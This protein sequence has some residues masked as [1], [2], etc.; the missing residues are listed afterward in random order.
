MRLLYSTYHSPVHRIES[1]LTGVPRLEG[2]LEQVTQ[3]LVGRQERGLLGG[4]GNLLA[5]G[6][7]ARREPGLSWLQSLKPWRV[8]GWHEGWTGKPLQ[9]PEFALAAAGDI[10]GQATDNIPRMAGFINLLKKGVDPQEAMRQVNLSLVSYNPRD[11]TALERKLKQLLPFYSFCMPVD[12]QILSQDGWKTYDQLAVG[13]PVL[14]L[15]HETGTL[16]WQPVQAINVFPHDGPLLAWQISRKHK[17]VRFEFTSNH[18]WPI[19]TETGTFAYCLASGESRRGRRHVKRRW[20]LGGDLRQHDRIP[21][22]GDF[23][24]KE[25]SIL[26]VRLAKLLGWIVTDGFFRRRPRGERTY[27]EARIYQS[28]HKHLQELIELTGSV[29]C[30]PHPI[31]GVVALNVKIDDLREIMKVFQTKADLCRIVC[32]LSREAAEAMWDAMFK[33]EGSTSA[34]GNMHFAQSPEINPEVL[35]AFQILCLMTGRTAHLSSVGCFVK[36]SK[37]WYVHDRITSFDYEGLVWCPTTA[38]GTWIARHDGAV[39]I[40][41]NSSRQIPYVMQELTNRPGGRLGMLIKGSSRAREPD[42]MAPDYVSSTM[43]VPIGASPEGGRRYLT[44]FGLMHEDPMAWAK[45]MQGDMRGFLT[46]LASRARPELKGAT[47]YATNRIFFQSGPTG[48]RDASDADPL[49]GRL[50]ANLRDIKTG[51]K[52]KKVLPLF[53]SLGL[54][55]AAANSPPSRLLTTARM[56][57]DPDKYKSVWPLALQLLT[58][59]RVTRVS[60]GAEEAILRE[61]AGQLMKRMGGAEFVRSYI[62]PEVLAQMDPESRALGEQLNAAQRIWSR[63]QRERK[64]A[65]E[66]GQRA[67]V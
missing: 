61:T 52:T 33:A 50:W 12:H 26:N 19:L 58:G 25:A 20:R 62:K 56:V 41:G 29:P 36:R 21:C 1:E 3:G 60:P 2:G 40:T 34:A 32:R 15:N 51:Q 53:G 42:A 64:K 5:T 47:E 24:T 13:E 49:L 27:A 31:S 38:N 45:L 4:I 16:E 6:V 63:R 30:K 14:T 22:T 46:E 28:P 18:R 66:K 65:E 17:K 9:N 43:S 44:S 7:G 8:R 11:Y 39:T 55:M 35:D 57:T 67:K 37:C 10:A 59:A 48:P 23:Q 54:E